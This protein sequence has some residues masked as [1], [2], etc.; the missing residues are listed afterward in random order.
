MQSLQH[1]TSAR[2]IDELVSN[3]GRAFDEYP[4]ERLNHT[5]VTLQSCLIETLKLFGDNA[6]KAPHLSKEKLD[7]KG[8]LPLNVTCPRE[9]VDA[10]SAS[11]GALDCDELDRVFAQ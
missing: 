1:R 2:S 9:V 11:L 3:V 6:Y 5:F 8:T 10:A 7:R 4:H